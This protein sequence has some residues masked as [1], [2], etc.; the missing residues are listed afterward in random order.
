MNSSVTN[1][2]KASNHIGSV[3]LI[4][5][6][7]VNGKK[8]PDFYDQLVVFIVRVV[9]KDLIFYLTIHSGGRNMKWI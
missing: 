8:C 6:R 1:A 7:L 3:F 2:V 5:F 9:Q 4:N